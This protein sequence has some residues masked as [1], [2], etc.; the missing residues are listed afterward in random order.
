MVRFHTWLADLM[1]HQDEIK[2][3]PLNANLGDTDEIIASI[4]VSGVYR[5][6]YAS[7]E[8]RHVVAGHHLYAAL[9]EMGQK[10]VPVA[11]IDGN[12]EQARRILIGDNQIARLA[13]MDDTRLL[14]L[15]DTVKDGEMGFAGTGFNEW[16][17][18]DLVTATTPSNVGGWFP[19]APE[20]ENILR[21]HECPS[22]GHI[23]SD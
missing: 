15:L 21:R 9:L 23:W 5:P 13:R 1:V 22:C 16:S 12:D 8:S 7:R 6:I 18:A 11:W 10:Y 19:S 3:D 17:Y 20:A 14:Q 2:P 4:E